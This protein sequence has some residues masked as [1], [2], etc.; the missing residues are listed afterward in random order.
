MANER[1]VNYC[2]PAIAEYDGTTD[3]L[4]HLS[5]FENEALLHRYTDGSSPASSSPPWLELPSSV[6]PTVYGSY[7]KLPGVPIHVLTS[8]HQ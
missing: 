8:I 3:P 4:E 1:A 7:R 5:C 6:Q 2:T